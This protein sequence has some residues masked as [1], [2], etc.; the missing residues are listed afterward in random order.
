MIENAN[1]ERNIYSK[2]SIKTYKNNTKPSTKRT[3]IE[4]SLLKST[5][6]EYSDK[7]KF[8]KDKSDLKNSKN[9]FVSNMKIKNEILFS[10][11]FKKYQK[12]PRDLN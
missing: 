3:M 5:D 6:R 4:N 12:P 7:N 10:K 11:N 9:L 2:K 8:S 1:S